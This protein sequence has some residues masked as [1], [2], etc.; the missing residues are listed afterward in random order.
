[1]MEQMSTVD[2]TEQQ[3]LII[4]SG[5]E[6]DEAEQAAADMGASGEADLDELRSAFHDLTEPSR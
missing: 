2:L 3:A 1:M 4:L 6:S 5:L